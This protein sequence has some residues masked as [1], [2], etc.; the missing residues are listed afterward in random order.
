V[1]IIACL[2]LGAFLS[3]PDPASMLIVAL[4]LS[5]VYWIAVIAWSASRS[6]QAGTTTIGE[7]RETTM[8]TKIHAASAIALIAVSSCLLG[9][10]FYLV[11]VVPEFEREWHE[12]NATLPAAAEVALNLSHF[13]K[14]YGL[15]FLPF[16]LL[17][18]SGGI[19][20]LILSV[21]KRRV[22]APEPRPT[23]HRMNDGAT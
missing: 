12:A 19:V 22:A 16:L 10:L 2:L 8:S 5:F 1:G 15:I 9:G 17:G 21:R 20:W 4:P 13:G 14:L 3:P 11:K 6:Q 18:I 23:S 7:E